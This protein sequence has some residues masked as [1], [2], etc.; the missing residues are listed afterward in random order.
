MNDWLGTFGFSYIGAVFLVLLVVPNLFWSKHKP[1]GYTAENENKI[2]RA[3]EM[4]GQIGVTCITL[5]FS[6]FNLQRIS[7]CSILFAAACLFMLLYELWWIR[8]FKSDKTS[9]DF[10]RSFCGIPV[11]GAVL[12]VLAF[13][14]LGFYGKNIWMLIVCTFLGIGHI[15]IHLQHKKEIKNDAD[16]KTES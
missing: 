14:C 6:D 4:L 3:F 5:C 2:L 10:Y 13:L 8:Y 7:P 1:E 12:P 16:T 9:A 15:G 11:A